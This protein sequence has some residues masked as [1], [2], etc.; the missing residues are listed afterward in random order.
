MTA[1]PVPHAL[2]WALTTPPVQELEHLVIV[3][4]VSCLVWGR[5][6]RWGG[7][8]QNQP[9]A[10]ESSSGA[11]SVYSPVDV[12]SELRVRGAS[13]SLSG[14]GQDTNTEK[15]SCSNPKLFNKGRFRKTI[16]PGKGDVC[17]IRQPKSLPARPCAQAGL[18]R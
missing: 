12:L 8:E 16:T 18:D 13:M 2:P 5:I 10:P 3:H 6:K 17:D 1:D 9:G 15:N 11:V 7:K 4:R 14:L